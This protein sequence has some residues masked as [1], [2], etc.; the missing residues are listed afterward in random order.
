MSQHGILPHFS[1]AVGAQIPWDDTLSQGRDLATHSCI[2][3]CLIPGG[4]PDALD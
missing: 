4:Q 3:A 1:I 2:A